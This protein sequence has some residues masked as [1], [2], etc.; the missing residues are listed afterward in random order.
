MSSAQAA[1]WA[2]YS[3]ITTFRCINT[4]EG[5]CGEAFQVCLTLLS[6]AGLGQIEGIPA[7]TDLCDVKGEAHSGHM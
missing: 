1:L 4:K 7:P 3:M 2:W 5:L 6:M